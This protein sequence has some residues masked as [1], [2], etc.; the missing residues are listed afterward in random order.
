MQVEG[1][2]VKKARCARPSAQFWEKL[3]GV[4]AAQVRWRQAAQSL[5]LTRWE[6][7][8]HSDSKQ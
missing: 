3:K 1:E 6:V 5:E 8:L 4:G 7:E 2:A